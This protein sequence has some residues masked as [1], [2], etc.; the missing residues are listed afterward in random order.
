M[1]FNWKTWT[2]A[3][4]VGSLPFTRAIL[5]ALGLGS[6]VVAQ[7]QEL[8]LA[9]LAAKR[10]DSQ[11]RALFDQVAKAYRD[12][13]AY[14]DQGEFVIAMKAEGKTQKQALPLKLTFVRPNKLDLDAGLV[15]ITS[16]GTTL[17]TAVNP[18]KRYTAVPAPSKIG[19]DT[20]RE[21][22]IGAVLFGGPAGVPMFVLLNLLTAP[23]PAAAVSQLGG[24]FQRA[25]VAAPD[26]KS[27]AGANRESS[28][29]LID[30][31][32]GRPSMLLTADS[33]TKLLSSIEMKIDPEQL[34]RGLPKGQTVSIDQFGW[35]SGAVV[36]QVPKDRSFVFEAPKDFA[37]VDSLVPQGKRPA[38][39]DKVGKPA[40]NFV[41]TVLNGPGKTKTITKAEFAGK[42]VV[43]DFWATWCKPCKVE[44]PEIQKLIET[45]ANSKKDVVVVALSQDDDP[46]DM[47]QVRKLVEKTLSDN[48]INLTGGSAGLIGLDP[49]KS[50]GEAFQIEG[51]PT[52]VILDGKGIVQSVHVGFDPEAAQ[53]FN[54]TL[55]KEIDEILEG[56]SPA[57]P[58]VK[59][60]EASSKEDK[61]KN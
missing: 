47:S 15:R 31:G 28:G 49:S 53:P 4:H 61:P 38:A 29:I 57:A 8:K 30:F 17:T 37:K 13:S 27:G 40:P 9:E 55:A 25:P 5:L 19:F 34:A 58:Q 12:L 16:D 35:I 51:Y 7:P 18:L 14:S 43:I 10:D 48:K 36:T 39:D 52:L 24:T 41:L 59:A 22:Q 26:P 44:L 3:F 33:D 56:K 6:P 20:F 60:K 21:G 54:K 42:V 32:Q 50:V 2:R 46:A 11:A 23:D 1:F 45:Y